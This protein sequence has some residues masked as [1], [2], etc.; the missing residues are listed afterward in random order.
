MTDADTRIILRDIFV[1]RGR[2]DVDAILH[3][4]VFFII[5]NAK[6]SSNEIWY[7]IYPDLFNPRFDPQEWAED[8]LG[9]LC[10]KSKWCMNVDY[11][12]IIPV[13]YNIV[14]PR[15]LPIPLD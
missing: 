15:F 7:Q 1:S 3:F 12:G 14:S 4:G 11:R 5:N 9:S 10:D 13:S 6:P 8:I 2:T